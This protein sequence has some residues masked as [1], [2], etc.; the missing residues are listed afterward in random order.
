MSDRFARLAAGPVRL[1]GILGGIASGKST[2]TR[3]L[4]AGGAT[5]FDADRAAHEALAEPGVRAA[6]VERWGESVL[7]GDGSIDRTRLARIVFDDAAERRALEALVHGHVFAA[8]EALA[9]RLAPGAL[10]VVD[11]ALLAET[12]L[13]EACQ[14]TILVDTPI[15]ERRRRAVAE[16]GWDPAELDRREAHQMS[17]ADKK[18]LAD[19]VVD[20]TAPPEEMA[21]AVDRFLKI[22]PRPDRPGGSRP[23]P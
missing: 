13:I 11:A 20:G 14:A 21:A 3:H 23:V 16:R 5:I 22:T 4:E 10:L 9:S 12:G 19:L 7:A 6:I 1:V 8:L 15:E 17:P 18:A 2:L